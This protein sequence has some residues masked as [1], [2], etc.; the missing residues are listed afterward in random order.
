NGQEIELDPLP[1]QYPDFAVWQRALPSEPAFQEQL[2]FWQERLV[3]LPELLELPTDHIRPAVQDFC[4]ARYSFTIPTELSNRLLELC[5]RFSVTP[6]V[7]F[8]SGFA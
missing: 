6:F 4:G 2:S 1:I 3:G 7:L 5:N 8:S